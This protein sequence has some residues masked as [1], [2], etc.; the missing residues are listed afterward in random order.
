MTCLGSSAMHWIE[1]TA[2]SR[3]SKAMSALQ[4]LDELAGAD[5]V[6]ILD[7][8]RTAKLTATHQGPLPDRANS[9]SSAIVSLAMSD[10]A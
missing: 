5:L 2:V 1:G 6:A 7:L 9:T 10:V 8:L 3:G 4:S